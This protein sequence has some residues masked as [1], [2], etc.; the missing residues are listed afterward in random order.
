[1][2]LGG[3]AFR[4]WIGHKGRALVNGVSALKT[5][6]PPP[7]KKAPSHFPPGEDWGH[8]CQTE[9]TNQET[10]ARHRM[11]RNTQPSELWEIN[12]CPLQA[13]QSVGFCYRSLNWLKQRGTNTGRK[14]W[15]KKRLVCP[16]LCSFVCL[17]PKCISGSQVME[18]TL[19]H[20]ST[21]ETTRKKLSGGNRNETKSKWEWSALWSPR[22]LKQGSTISDVFPFETYGIPM[23]LNIVGSLQIILEGKIWTF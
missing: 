7:K 11:W 5:Q 4:K 13:T 23:G 22:S 14:T 17:F 8:S 15:V 20:S 10:F 9:F 19:F 6:T 18:A 16:F 12:S 1:M 3:G 2:A 21:L